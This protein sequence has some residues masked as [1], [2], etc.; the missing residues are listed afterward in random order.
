MP[1][2]INTEPEQIIEQQARLLAECN[3]CGSPR[4][5]ACYPLRYE[6]NPNTSLYSIPVCHTGRLRTAMNHPA[7][8]GP[9]P[10]LDLRPECHI[11]A[12]GDPIG[13]TRAKVEQSRLQPCPVRAP[14]PSQQPRIVMST[15]VWGDN[16]PLC[17]FAEPIDKAQGKNFAVASAMATALTTWGCGLFRPSAGFR[18]QHPDPRVEQINRDALYRCD[19]IVAY[20]D[21]HTP[22]IGVPAEIEAATNRGIPAVV[23]YTGESFVLAG[24]PLVTVIR[25]TNDVIAALERAVKDHPRQ[26]QQP[27]PDD[28]D[29]K[30]DRFL[31]GHTR[32]LSAAETVPG[33]KHRFKPHDPLRLVIADGAQ[34]PT[35]VY[36]DDAGI[37]LTTAREITIE[38]GDYK[39]IHT[40]VTATQLPAGY[41]GMITGR[42]SALRKWRLHIPVAIIDPGW[43]GPL[44]VGVWN[45]GGNPVTVKPGDRLGQLILVPNVPAPVIQVTEVDEHPRGLKGFGSSG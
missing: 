8:R 36:Q 2:T 13:H 14:A 30:M 22:S 45:L 12:T 24:N 34:L 27:G 37:D 39:D 7:W 18:V 6:A 3:R 44:F 31:T 38:P 9:K 16:P 29:E 4:G 43:R 15:P 40:Q 28:F 41:W 10:N 20:L 5:R 19:A 11:C 32:I 42:S 33:L 1:A 23:H 21:E 26:E 25:D 35:R 17:Y